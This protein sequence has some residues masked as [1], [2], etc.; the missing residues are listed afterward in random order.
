MQ[1]TMTEGT[2]AAIGM[3]NMFNPLENLSNEVLCLSSETLEKYVPVP[4]KGQVLQDLLIGIK[5]FKYAVRWK[6]F[7]MEKARM[8]K[9]GILENKVRSTKLKERFEQNEPIKEVQGLG[10]GLKRTST[11]N[12]APMAS[13][14]VEVFLNVVAEQ[15]LM[16]LDK[17]ESQ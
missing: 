1:A 16:E 14:Q 9:E 12:L 13:P 17:S 8:E 4:H 7:W 11:A 2:A 10:T 5:R 6:W 15:L 3:I